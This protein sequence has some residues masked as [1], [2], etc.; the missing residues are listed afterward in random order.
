MKNLKLPR[1]ALSMG[2]FQASTQLNTDEIKRILELETRLG[3]LSAINYTF[4]FTGQ[5][6]PVF[7]DRQVGSDESANTE[8]AVELG[9]EDFL[10]KSPALAQLEALK[11]L[12]NESNESDQRRQSN[13]RENPLAATTTS[14]LLDHS[15]LENVLIINPLMHADVTIDI[16]PSPVLFEALFDDVPEK[17]LSLVT[18]RSTKSIIKLNFA[19][20]T[21]AQIRPHLTNVCHF[22]QA[23]GHWA[24]AIDPA[25]GCAL[26]GTS[27]AKKMKIMATMDDFEVIYAKSQITIRAITSDTTPG[28][29]LTNAPSDSTLIGDLRLL[30]ALKRSLSHFYRSGVK[31]GFLAEDGTIIDQERATAEKLAIFEEHLH[32]N[33]DPD[34][35]LKRFMRLYQFMTS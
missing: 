17:E 28:I 9:D 29:I 34:F 14:D 10:P 11:T 5:S 6:R 8:E 25:T 4:P 23:R 27:A 26:Y 20:S 15:H 35:N 2:Q 1:R 19:T 18:A 21:A 32:F 13:W 12:E 33:T 16:F 30:C 31:N 3:V 22:L 24:N 7:P